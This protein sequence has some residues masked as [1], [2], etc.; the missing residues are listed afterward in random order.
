M[1][2]PKFKTAYRLILVGAGFSCLFFLAGFNF[3]N[4]T[5]SAHSYY[6]SEIICSGPSKDKN[7]VA[8]V[9]N[10]IRIF[11]GNSLEPTRIAD[12]GNRYTSVE[13]AKFI[14]LFVQSSDDF[15]HVILK[16]Y[17]VKSLIAG[18]LLS[19][20]LYL[21]RKF[22]YL[23]NLAAR[24]LLLMFSA[25][26][27][28]F[29]VSGVYSAPIAIVAMFL[30]LLILKTFMSEHTLNLRDYIFLGLNFFISTSVIMSLRFETTAYLGFAI[31]ILVGQ[32]VLRRTLKTPRTTVMTPTTIFG[33]LLVLFALRNESL[34]DWISASFFLRAKVFTPEYAETSKSVQV[35]GD[36]GFAA[37]SPVSLVVN[38][39]S[40]M[41]N[42]FIN[43]LS[44]RMNLVGEWRTVFD[45]LKI[46]YLGCAW[47]AFVIV[48]LQALRV[49]TSPFLRFR[50]YDLGKVLN[51]IPALL[52]LLA[53]IFVPYV[54][55]VSWFLWY[56]LPLIMVL[57]FFAE[58]NELKSKYLVY[59]TCLV[60]A[61]NFSAFTM[62]NYAFG[63]LLIGGMNLSWIS[64]SLFAT[65]VSSLLFKQI[66]VFFGELENE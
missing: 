40:N 60:A 14:N 32:V 13:F 18:Y 2:I 21:I 45:T 5:T 22:K 23:K 3:D 64:M 53:L 38:S 27:L 31:S 34:R 19:A 62:S 39:T 8:D 11:R 15:R 4:F 16:I 26:Y 46:V 28:L 44:D 49:A 35:L 54:A 48:F 55:R 42:Q 20:S 66:S 36:L 61:V 1:Q 12:Y 10:D 29:G 43:A 30:A 17:I 51:S 25:P 59:L 52:V 7:C 47:A 6:A 37:I 9:Q 56:V 63:H 57:L 24:L 58:A 41:S 33:G 65:V 50:N